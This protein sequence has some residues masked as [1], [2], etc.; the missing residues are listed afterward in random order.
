MALPSYPPVPWHLTGFDALLMYA[1]LEDTDHDRSRKV[2]RALRRESLRLGASLSAAKALRHSDGLGPR[3]HLRVA[4]QRVL[5][6]PS[7]AACFHLLS[8]ESKVGNVAEARAA[9]CRMLSLATEVGDLDDIA[10]ARVLVERTTAIQEP[11]SERPD[12]FRDKLARACSPKAIGG[13]DAYEPVVALQREALRLGGRATAIRCARAL[14]HIAAHLLDV[15][16]GVRF[17]HDLVAVEASSFSYLALGLAHERAG[18]AEDARLE[19][20]RALRFACVEGDLHRATKATAGL[21]RTNGQSLVTEEELRWT[22]PEAKREPAKVPDYRFLL[23][24][25][26]MPSAAGWS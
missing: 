6:A 21:L 1:S 5:E 7:A 15:P 18:S 22:M 23:A 26:G 24:T 10:T 19:L 8:E 2:V 12:T 11:M 20:A 14:L 9:A 13:P 25:L 17:A 4:R 3:A 16:A